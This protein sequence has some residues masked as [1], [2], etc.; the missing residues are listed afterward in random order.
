MKYAVV[1]A[2]AAL[3]ALPLSCGVGAAY[4]CFTNA[5]C[6]E[7]MACVQNACVDGTSVAKDAGFG[8][9][10]GGGT[11]KDGGGAA[12]DGGVIHNDGGSFDAGGGAKDGGGVR[13]AGSACDEAECATQCAPLHSFCDRMNGQCICENAGCNSDAMCEKTCYPNPGTC[14]QGNC[15]CGGCS[16]A[17]GDSFTCGQSDGCGGSCPG[18]CDDASQKCEPTPGGT[19]ICTGSCAPACGNS[20]CGGPDG[21]GG[22]CPGQC[23]DPGQSCQLLDGGGYACVAQ[24][25]D[26]NGAP[27]DSPCEA[28][29]VCA[30]GNNCVKLQQSGAQPQAVGE[31]LPSCANG[32]S[33]SDPADACIC[34]ETDAVGA[35]VRSSCFATGRLTGNFTSKVMNSCQDQPAQTDIGQGSM[36]LAYGGKSYAWNLFLACHYAQGADDYVVLYGLKVCGQN[37]CPDYLQF[38]TQTSSLAGVQTPATFQVGGGSVYIRHDA[39]TYSGQALTDAWLRGM[40][41]WGSVTYTAAGTS[42]KQTLSGSA[43]VTMLSYDVEYCNEQTGVPVKCSAMP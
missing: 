26:P 40:S 21:C 17:C 20:I 36:T 19:W 35:C 15:A 39:Y 33:C 28:D 11:S 4:N 25:C 27:A 24:T 3:V 41:G 42:G 6:P 18:W 43:D 13:D 37:A 5:D 10:D 34:A 31:C 23:A 14:V 32:G 1:A 2:M 12:R 16:G 9:E 22:S 8:R 30:C 7:G 29:K 38:F